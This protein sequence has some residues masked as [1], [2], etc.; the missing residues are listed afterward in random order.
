MNVDD[1]NI[2]GVYYTPASFQLFTKQICS[3]PL[4]PSPQVLIPADVSTI[5]IWIDTG[6]WIKRWQSYLWK[7]F[8]WETIIN[9]NSL[10]LF[11]SLSVPFK[12]LKYLIKRGFKF[13]LSVIEVSGMKKIWH[14]N[15][16]REYFF[17]HF[18]LYDIS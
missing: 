18:S 4:W 5:F 12:F 17:P 6:F 13:F 11:L 8:K 3:H 9:S 2:A 7:I 16:R 15:Y 1:I 10:I 14:L